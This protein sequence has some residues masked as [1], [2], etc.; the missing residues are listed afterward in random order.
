MDNIKKEAERQRK[1]SKTT[2]K[3]ERR[4]LRCVI[5]VVE[6]TTLSHAGSSLQPQPCPHRKQLSNADNLDNRH[7]FSLVLVYIVWQKRQWTM[8]TV[9]PRCT[10]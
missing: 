3:D 10:I 1:Y 6:T 5:P 8:D 7:Y 2:R 9:G 4:I